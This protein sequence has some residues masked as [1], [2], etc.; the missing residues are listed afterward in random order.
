M[1]RY[2]GKHPN[3]CKL[4]AIVSIGNPYNLYVSIYLYQ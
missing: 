4:K 2:A 3:E 1:L